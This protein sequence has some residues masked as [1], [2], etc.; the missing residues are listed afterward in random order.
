M[1]GSIETLA[2]TSLVAASAVAAADNFFN[3]TPQRVA[4]RPFDTATALVAGTPANTVTWYTGEVGT[5]PARATATARVDTS[6][7]V[8]Y[9]MRANEEGIR[10]IVQNVAALA[11]VTFSPSDP[12]AVARNA[13]LNARVG[14]NLGVPVGTQKI[15]DIAG[16]A[17]RR[18]AH[19]AERRRTAS[20]D[21]EHA[22]RHAG[23][24]R[25]RVDRGG[26][27][28]DPGAADA[29]AGLAADDL[30]ALPDQSGELSLI[31]GVTQRPERSFQPQRPGLSATACFCTMN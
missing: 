6:I 1:T 7:S 31:S 8:S 27:G 9:G 16:R 3:G 25:G 26:R 20:A 23:G 10:W 28:A 12:D 29:A 11:A 4:G 13:A 15:E 19:A 2:N 14:T 30:A 22:R 21:Q 17:R 18:A 5:D 24:D